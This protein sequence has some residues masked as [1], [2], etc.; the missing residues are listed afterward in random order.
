SG[1][2][3]GTLALNADGSFTYTPT[4]NYNGSDSFT[5]K[6]N[7]G[8]LSGN[9]ATVSLTINAVN[10]Q[11]VVAQGIADIS[12]AEDEPFSFTIPANTFFDVDGD[13][14]TYTARLAG[15]PGT[16]LP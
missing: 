3:H 15:N 5:Y 12:I 16:S 11:P 14:L 7:D 8:S 13:A 6:A 2:A 10:D 4:A 9:V 1:P